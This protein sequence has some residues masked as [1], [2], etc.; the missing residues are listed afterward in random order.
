MGDTDQCR[1]E[2]KPEN[3]IPPNQTDAKKVR[4]FCPS[5]LT[6]GP[7][8]IDR[9]HGG[10]LDGNEVILDGKFPRQRPQEPADLR[11]RVNAWGLRANGFVQTE[12]TGRQ[13]GF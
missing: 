6:G 13:P 1:P 2:A 10:T 3:E 5:F 4:G 8:A 7:R 12:C 9:C 11:K